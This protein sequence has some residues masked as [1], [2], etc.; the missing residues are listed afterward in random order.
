MILSREWWLSATLAATVSFAILSPAT[1]QAPSAATPSPAAPGDVFGEEVTLVEKPIIYMSG[2]GMWDSAFETITGSFKTVN[3]AMAKA[4]IKANGPLMTIYTSTDDTGFQYEAAVPV[5]KAPTLG[6]DSGVTVGMSP[7]GK[8]LKFIHRGS[9]DAM[10]ATYEAITNYLDE[11][12]LEA[13]DLFIEQ[14][15]KDPL[16][17]PEDDLVIEVY[18]PLK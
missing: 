9:Y 6:A 12:Q 18:V 7:A 15:M 17:T 5:E 16:T 10:D 14:Y 13:K 2:S 3:A 1:A 4:G 11:K 8:A